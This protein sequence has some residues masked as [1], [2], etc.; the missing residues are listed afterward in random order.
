MAPDPLAHEI[1]Y[2]DPVSAFEK[3]AQ[4]PMSIFL[5]SALADSPYSRYSF[6]ATDPFQVLRAKNGLVNLAGVDEVGD[7]FASLGRELERFRLAPVEGLPPF[8]TGAAGYFAY[9]LCHHLEKLPR[10]KRDDLYLPDL[11][12]GFFDVVVAFDNKESRAWIISSGF[13]AARRDARARSRIEEFRAR[14]GSGRPRTRTRIPMGSEWISDFTRT[15]YE[16]TVEKII[17]YIRAGD[18]YQA[19]LSQ[20]YQSRLAESVHPFEVYRRLRRI[21]PAPFAAYLE[22]EDFAIASSSPE[23]FLRL[24][25]SRVETRPIK[26]TRARGKTPKEDRAQARELI[27]S[28][29]DRCEN[30][31]IVD[32]L[33]ND[34]S[35]V[36]DHHSVEVPQ[37][38]KL[39]SFASVHHLVSTVVG[40]LRPGT[41]AADLLR[42]SFPGG[43]ITGAPKI[44]AMEIIAELEP[45]QR[46]P[47]CGSIGYIG[48]DGALDTSIV[49]R[50]ISFKDGVATF[51]VGGGIVADSNPG[52]EFE[53]TL[54]KGRC[55]FACLDPGNAADDPPDR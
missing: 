23:R 44:R 30:V 7:P 55:L 1:R 49:I 18:I 46:G 26:G 19:N 39:E 6:V 3:L 13:P 40:E 51:Q 17:E 5:D 20:R 34:L 2:L 14:L 24:R 38:F 8:Q 33:R 37:L 22:G 53:E 25:G 29:K 48:F 41:T 16:E 54:A 35:R 27:A 9:D 10:A 11:V 15:A 31:M 21:N 36:C 42:A 47:Y 32:L 28:E 43:S 50:T 4:G 45:T 12:L 52:D